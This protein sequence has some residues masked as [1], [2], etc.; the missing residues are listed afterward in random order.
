MRV[1]QLGSKQRVPAPSAAHSPAPRSTLA[2]CALPF[3]LLGLV[4]GCRTAPIQDVVAAPLPV[5]C[6][7]ATTNDVDEAI[8]RAG[9]KLGWKIDRIG[10]GELRGTWRFKHHEAVVSITHHDGLLNIRYVESQNLL[11]EGSQIHRNYNELVQRLQ[12]QIQREPVT[13]ESGLRCPRD[14]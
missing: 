12:T 3:L 8:W 13:L 7:D 5:P 10:P 9:R 6:A 2:G 11:H 14:I 4:A 1:W